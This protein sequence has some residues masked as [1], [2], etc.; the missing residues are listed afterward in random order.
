MKLQ[1]QLNLYL[2]LIKKGYY[3]FATFK[4][5]KKQIEK[6]IKN[7][8][9]NDP[10]K[11]KLLINESVSSYKEKYKMHFAFILLLFNLLYFTLEQIVV[12][13]GSNVSSYNAL[14]F[15]IGFCL[16]FCVF[17]FYA[18]LTFK[19]RNQLDFILIF[20]FIIT[21]YVNSYSLVLLHSD[22]KGEYT[23]YQYLFPMIFKGRINTY[24]SLTAI[25]LLTSITFFFLFNFLKRRKRNSKSNINTEQVPSSKK[26]NRATLIN[27]ILVFAYALFQQV[28]IADPILEAYVPLVFFILYLP[29]ILYLL[30]AFQKR[31]SIDFILITITFI[32]I[33]FDTFYPLYLAKI[34]EGFS[35]KVSPFLS[36]IFPPF[37]YSYSYIYN[38]VFYGIKYGIYLGFLNF[39]I[40]LIV[41][42]LSLIKAKRKAID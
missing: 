40:N 15:E 25:N 36:P 6:N 10:D 21:F 30:I 7:N 35:S 26:F 11:V 18:L 32:C 2:A 12:S 42:I 5:E 29:Y 39:L 34:P 4:E 38:D 31:K 14:F 37:I 8:N 20:S 17:L 3:S 1:Y 19:K 28:L 22:L 24:F 27:L 33:S 13:N 9:L 16:V 41:F 23:S